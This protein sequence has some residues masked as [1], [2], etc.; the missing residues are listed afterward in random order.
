MLNIYHAPE[1]VNWT[2]D[3]PKVFLAG[4]IDNGTATDWQASLI[5]TLQSKNIAID[6]LNPRRKHWDSTWETTLENPLFIEQ[7]N[8]ELE[9]LE[10]ATCHVFY[11]APATLAPITL[12]ELGLHGRA[13]KAIVCCPKGYWRKG[14]VDMVCLRYGITQ[15]DTLEELADTLTKKVT[16]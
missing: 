16:I 10:K 8:W 2:N 14:N 11:F 12:L 9:G 13:G 4:S 3:R 15:V 1:A 5:E 7:V 6:I